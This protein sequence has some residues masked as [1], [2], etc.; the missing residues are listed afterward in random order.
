MT[1]FLSARQIRIF[2]YPRFAEPL[3]VRH[4]GARAACQPG[5]RRGCSR[6]SSRA[7]ARDRCSLAEACPVAMTATAIA[8]AINRIEGR[9]G[10]ELCTAWSGG[11]RGSQR[12]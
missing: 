7:T 11:S 5:R 2:D 12:L 4:P 3:R 1:A 8:M 10:A 9:E 6:W